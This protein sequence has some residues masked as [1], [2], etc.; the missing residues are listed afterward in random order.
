MG[1]PPRGS[2]ER[3]DPVL[4]QECGLVVNGGAVLPR[5]PDNTFTFPEQQKNTSAQFRSS[6]FVVVAVRASL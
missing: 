2:L 1:G 4:Y 5:K 6:K 3:A